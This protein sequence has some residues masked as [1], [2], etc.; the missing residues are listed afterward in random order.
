M[1]TA[2]IHIVT[3][4]GLPSL[5]VFR[6]LQD[7]HLKIREGLFVAEGVEAV[8]R[9]LTA[10]LDVH[11]LL[12]TPQRLE[13]LRDCLRPDVP[14]Y[15]A[16]RSI[17]EV[18]I[19]FPVN[20]GGVIACAPRPKP[21][22]LDTVISK[23][24]SCLPAMVVAMENI[25]DAQ[26]IGL[27]VRNAV[28]FGAGAAVL[29]GCCDPPYRRAVR[30]SMGNILRLPFHVSEDLAQSLRHLRDR[31]G[32]TIIAAAV[33]G[34]AVPIHTVS[35]PAKSVLVFGSEGEGLS[36]E[37][38]STCDT[39]VIIPMMPGSDSVNV[40]VASGVFLYHFSRPTE[41]RVF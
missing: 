16:E 22:D 37:V 31:H 7:K 34:S 12:T 14:V 33:S 28:A 9:L 30:V 40:A 20:R 2:N 4:A 13:R 1:T 25:T 8:R 11:S 6:Q 41:L 5:D 38:L 24:C 15:V 3:D 26:N 36:A 23:G 10:E 19:G 27:I 18:V 17:M 35:P 29:G 21:F 39:Q 32:F